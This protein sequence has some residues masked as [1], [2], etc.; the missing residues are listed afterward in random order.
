MVGFLNFKYDGNTMFCDSLHYKEKTKELWAFGKVQI[1]KADTLNLFCDSLYYNGKTKMAKLKGHVRLRDRE[2]KVI[3]DT[4]EYNT[5]TTKATY[6]YGGRIE[7]STTNEVLTSKFGYFYPNT[8]ESYFKGN[9]VYTS[10]KLK[11]T[12]DTLHYN[13]LTHKIYFKGPSKATTDS[14]TFYCDNGWY[15]VQT[16]EGLLRENAKID[17]GR[18][19]VTGDSLYYAP[20]RKFAEGKGNVMVVDTVQKIAFLGGHL[21]SDGTQYRDIVSQNPLIK[22]MKSKDTLYLRADTLIH[23]RDSLDSTVSI[24]GGRDVRVF[25]NKI[26]AKSDS[27]FYKKQEGVMDFYGDAHFWSYNSE[28]IADTIRAFIKN[29]TLVEKA[30]LYTPA[31]VVN[32]LDSGAYYNQLSG[33]E[34]WAYFRNNELVKSELI[35]NAKTIYYPEEEQKTDTALLIKRMGMNR[36]FSSSIVVYLDSGEVERMSFIKQPDGKFYPLDQLEPNEMKLP[37]FKWNPALR[38]K[39]WQELLKSMN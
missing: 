13:Y 1:N 33:K 38:P 20:K 34:I 17:Q 35:G 12:T 15:D 4:L 8:E 7:N 22:L 19:V 2:Y 3:T 32:E 30:H 10:D 29:D 11:M 24:R 6:K 16:E 28:L 9:V 25:Q 23:L 27:M 14:S 36:L 18:R 39:T 37:E 5:K 21:I 26:Q 31:F